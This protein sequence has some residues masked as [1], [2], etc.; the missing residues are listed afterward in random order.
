VDI[1]KV[2]A[3]I[4]TGSFLNFGQMCVATKRVYIHESIYDAFLQA[5]VKVIQS[6]KVGDASKND[7]THGPVQN[8]A[9]VVLPRYPAVMLVRPSDL[10][11]RKRA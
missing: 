11:P 2:A 4:V 3:Q 7:S 1:R 5:M 10:M 8:A 6:L 9:M